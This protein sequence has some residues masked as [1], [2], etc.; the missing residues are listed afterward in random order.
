[1][2]GQ[3]AGQRRDLQHGALPCRPLVQAAAQGFQIFFPHREARRHGVAAVADEQV[4]AGP[5]A[6]VQVETLHA[7]AAALA[8]AVLVH[9]DHDDRAAGALH[10]PGRHD[11]DDAGVPVPAPQQDHTILQPLRLLL[12]QFLS[13]L[14]DLQ[15]SL[16]PFRVDLVEFMGQLLGAVRVLTQHQLQGRHRAVHAAGRVDAGRNGVA[17]ILRCDGFSGKAHFFQQGFHAGAVGLLQLPQAGL[18]QGAVLSGQGHHVRH[19]A[20]SGQVAAVI[21]HFLRGAVVQRGAQLKGHA[22]AAQPFEGA[23]IVLPAGVHHGH[24]LGQGLGRQMVVGDDKVDAQ[25][26]GK[27]GLGYSGD[28]VVH[29]HDEP[30]ALVVDGLDGV[31]RQAVAIALAAGQH[32]FDGGAHALEVLI[33]QCRGSHAV[34]VVVAEHHDGL[35]IVDGLPDALAGFFHIGEQGGVAQLLF[36]GQ[37]GE[38][39]G[40]VGDAAGRQDA[41]QQG[42][43]LLLGGQRGGIFLFA[44]RLL[45]HGAVFQFFGTLLRDGMG[46]LPDGG[47]VQRFQVPG[48]VG[49]WKSL[50]VRPSLASIPCRAAIS[51]E[52][53]MA[54]SDSRL[55]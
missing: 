2:D 54:T 13:G 14:E 19:G 5:D 8:L 52:T 15:F 28:A 6:G 27:V 29:R 4:G 45:V 42:R 37:Q 32:A 33:Q 20:H 53:S 3:I 44:P 17:D 39:V 24:C 34:H 46:Q 55:S 11:A 41:G 50:P 21:Q 48:T 12:Q 38:R 26:C 18:D 30:I 25:L 35:A 40:R 36:P 49:H 9:R 1:M 47:A 10:Q 7:A 22:C 43:L 16:L 23:G 51:L 31:A